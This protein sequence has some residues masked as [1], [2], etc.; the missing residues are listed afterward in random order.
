MPLHIHMAVGP[1]RHALC[2]EE[3]SLPAP[4]RGSAP[5]LVD[6]SVAGQQ[7]GFRC[8]AQRAAHHPRVAGPASPG[9]NDAIGG[10]PSAGYLAYDVE[11][12]VAECPCLFGRHLVRIV[13]HCYRKKRWN[14]LSK[15][16]VSTCPPMAWRISS[17]VQKRPPSSSSAEGRM[18]PS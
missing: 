13:F 15:L 7:G 3:H 16:G 10:D 17:I 6:H 12:I 1:E 4:A 2:F 5:F 9:G 14:S 8:V 11:H 18:G